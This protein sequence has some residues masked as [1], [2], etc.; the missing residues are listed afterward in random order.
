MVGVDGLGL[1][2]YEDKDNNIIALDTFEHL[3]VAIPG[4][5]SLRQVQVPSK[6]Q[7]HP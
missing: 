5:C 7:R 2:Q 3:T 6:M 4:F 1:T